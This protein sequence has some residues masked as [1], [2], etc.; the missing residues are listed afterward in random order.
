MKALVLESKANFSVKDMEIPVIKPNQVLVKVAYVGICG[1]DLARYF[2]GKVHNYPTILGHEF[3][4]YY[5][6]RKRSAGIKRGRP[7][8]SSSISSV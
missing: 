6:N 5:G 1:S 4:C 2:D 8:C 7:R 3:W